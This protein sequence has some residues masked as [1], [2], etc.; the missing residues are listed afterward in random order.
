MHNRMKERNHYGRLFLYFLDILFLQRNYELLFIEQSPGTKIGFVFQIFVFLR[1][2]KPEKCVWR[3]DPRALVK[4][5]AYIFRRY[6]L[7]KLKLV[8]VLDEETRELIGRRIGY[9]KVFFAAGVDLRE[10][11][12]EKYRSILHLYFFLLRHLSPLKI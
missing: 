7:P 4:K 11:R 12:E 2:L 5:K 9:N 10:F 1:F 3:I 6:I 8:L